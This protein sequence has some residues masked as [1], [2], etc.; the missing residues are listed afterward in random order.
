LKAFMH[1]DERLTLLYSLKKAGFY[2][3]MHAYEYV[4]GYA[5]SII[6]VLALH[7]GETAATL[8][9]NKYARSGSEH[10]VL[11]VLRSIRDDVKVEVRM[12]NSS[13]KTNKD[14]SKAK[15]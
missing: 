1:P 13:W 4:L 8:Y 5:G 7:P 9:L 12:E 10:A 3:R 11:S 6:G 15:P 14:L 2:V